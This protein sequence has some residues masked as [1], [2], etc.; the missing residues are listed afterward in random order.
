[1]AKRLVALVAV[2]APILAIGGVAFAQLAGHSAVAAVSGAYAGSVVS[3][4]PQGPRTGDSFAPAAVAPALPAL[5][6]LDGGAGQPQ[7]FRLA[8]LDTVLQAT[9][10]SADGGTSNAVKQADAKDLAD[11]INAALALLPAGAT[12][13][14]VNAA[15]A[16]AVNA[17]ISAHNGVADAVVISAALAVVQNNDASPAV[18]AAV[19]YVKT[20]PVVQAALAAMTVAQQ[21]AATTITAAVAP[22]VTAVAVA[23][24][25]TG[26]TSGGV[27]SVVTTAP[28][29][30]SS[31][32]GSSSG[33]TG[34]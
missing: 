32:T 5:A 30:T 22:T 9:D 11:A 3:R 29:I 33:Y 28:A 26:T 21:N 23:F 7:A 6:D 12:Q 17:Y 25:S 24:N 27:V 18:T 1:M 14:Q 4:E 2:A 15:V 16:N 20:T 8:L 31:L 34:A 10:T 19:T 13:D